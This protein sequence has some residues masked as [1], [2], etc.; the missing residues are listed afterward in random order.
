MAELNIR[1]QSVDRISKGGA[2]VTGDKAGEAESSSELTLKWG[3]QPV[4]VYVCDEAAGC[5][6]FDKIEEVVLKDEKV[7]LGMK[8]FKTVK[9]H[10][11]DAGLDPVLKDQGKTVPRMMLVD[12]TKMKVTVIEAKKVKASSLYKAM[13][14]VAG[15]VYKE[16]L[17]KVVKTHLK[18]LTEQDQLANAEKVLSEKVSRLG[19]EEGKKAEKELAEVKKEHTEVKAELKA[20]AK[21]TADLWKLTPKAKKKAA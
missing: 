12:P 19:G 17:D 7:A 15:K 11:D 13:K 3:D 21:K 10:P 2:V 4:L 5:E 8:A 9:M 18:L 16:K 1:W 6:G 20:L 14:K